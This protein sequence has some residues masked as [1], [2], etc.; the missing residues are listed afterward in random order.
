MVPPP[1]F[2]SCSYEATSVS[3]AQRRWAEPHDPAEA[4]A[5]QGARLDRRQWPAQ[6]DG[7]V[8]ACGRTTRRSGRWHPHPSPAA[9]MTGGP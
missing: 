7:D 2:A 8:T 5:D 3:K 1:G 9:R 4:V 6:P